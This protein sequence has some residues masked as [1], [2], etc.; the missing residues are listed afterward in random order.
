[1]LLSDHYESRNT[2]L[3]LGGRI[4]KIFLAMAFALIMF[5]GLS[6]GDPSPWGSFE[7]PLYT[8]LTQKNLDMLRTGSPTFAPFK[9]ALVSDPQVVVSHLRDCRTQIDRR[10]D[11]DFTLLSG[12]LTDR[13]LRREFEWAAKILVEF[14]RPVLTV[15]GNHD[16]LLYGE[17]IYKKMFGPLNYTFIYNDVKI[18]MWNNNPYEWGYPD[19]NW[20]EE[21]IKSH[22]RVIIV[23]HQPPGV[24]DRYPEINTLW[25][26]LYKYPSVLGSVSGHLHNWG[27]QNI[28]G[29]P[30]VTVARVTDT[31]W[32]I[33]EVTEEGL[34][35]QKCKG[36]TCEKYP[37]L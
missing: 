13:S 36:A 37:A 28:F 29:K 30:A 34:S 19:I 27:Y 24:V 3:C 6:C 16:G 31:N 18:I 26:E 1:M 20:L 11:I 22:P 25:A 2:L 32:G 4:M 17:E 15:V 9:V 33:M 12:D 21:Q 35:F 8:N 7:T 14:R 10:D 5:G 23:T